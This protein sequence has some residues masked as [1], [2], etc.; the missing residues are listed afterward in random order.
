MLSTAA[1]SKQIKCKDQL[2]GKHEPKM[3]PETIPKSS[4][5]IA[6]KITPAL[7]PASILFSK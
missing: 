6:S 5:L 3:N 1:S 2:R 7:A 4:M